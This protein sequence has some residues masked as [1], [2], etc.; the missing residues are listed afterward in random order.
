MPKKK[1]Q[2]K[3]PNPIKLSDLNEQILFYRDYFNIYSNT[4]KQMHRG[5]ILIVKQFVSKIID[6]IPVCPIFNSELF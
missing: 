1:N 5:D 6:T 4:L 2:K 3:T